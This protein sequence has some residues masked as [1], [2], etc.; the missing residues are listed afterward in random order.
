MFEVRL[1]LVDPTTKLP[2]TD[3]NETIILYKGQIDSVSFKAD[4]SDIG[5]NTF[6]IIAASPLASLDAT[7][8]FYTSKS[9]MREKV[10]T[11]DS[12][13][14]QVYQGSGKIRLKWGKV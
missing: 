7:K 6:S 9:F 2:I 14:D 8:P 13:F 3:I 11:T 5:E 4:L 10:L 1:L 12:S